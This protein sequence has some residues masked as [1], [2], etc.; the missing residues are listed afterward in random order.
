MLKRIF[1]T[2]L[3]NF[4]DN[5]IDSFIANQEL[6]IELFENIARSIFKQM[7]M[8]KGKSLTDK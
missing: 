1:F 3:N 2:I 8:P 6:G 5:Y 7:K 4:I